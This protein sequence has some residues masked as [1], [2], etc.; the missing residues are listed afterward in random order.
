MEKREPANSADKLR[1][2][3]NKSL[4]FFYWLRFYAEAR[5][6]FSS[7]ASTVAKAM[8]DKK[9]TEDKKKRF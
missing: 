3:T 6:E 4:T 7:Y 2:A 8:A 1:E 5:I 9:A